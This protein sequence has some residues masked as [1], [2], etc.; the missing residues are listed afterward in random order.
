[1]RKEIDNELRNGSGIPKAE[2]RN[3][4]LRPGCRIAALF[5]TALAWARD[6]YAPLN[7]INEVAYRQPWIAHCLADVFLFAGWIPLHEDQAAE[8]IDPSG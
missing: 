7:G 4:G 8:K 2:S 1:V 6:A 3:L 5:N